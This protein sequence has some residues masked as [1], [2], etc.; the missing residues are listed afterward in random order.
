MRNEQH[1]YIFGNHYP[2]PYRK[3]FCCDI[4]NWNEIDI[5]NIEIV[6]E[7]ILT[8]IDIEAKIHYRPNL[9]FS[10]VICILINSSFQFTTR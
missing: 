1:G 7:R 4:N 8:S 9:S 5:K 6:F 2:P 3:M 10:A